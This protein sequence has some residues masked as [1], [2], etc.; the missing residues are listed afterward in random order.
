M[1]HELFNCSPLHKPQASFKMLRLYCGHLI[2]GLSITSDGNDKPRS[3]T[4]RTT[5]NVKNAVFQTGLGWTHAHQIS[6]QAI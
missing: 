6:E 3:K 2:E 5:S 4:A 1:N